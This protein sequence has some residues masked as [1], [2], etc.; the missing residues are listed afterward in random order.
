M[1]IADSAVTLQYLIHEL[2]TIEGKFQCEANV[3]VIKWL[4]TCLHRKGVV[5]IARD[6]KNFDIRIALE[7]RFSLEI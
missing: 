6:F 5:L 7:Q 1:V 3:W 2:L 4:N